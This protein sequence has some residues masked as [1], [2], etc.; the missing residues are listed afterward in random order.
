MATACV[1]NGVSYSVPATSEENW[2]GSTKV[3]GLLIAL[4]T[5]GFQKTGGNFTLSADVDFGGSAGL[6]AAYCKSRS[7]S[8]ASAGIVRLGNA[9]VISWRNAAD[10]A[11]L[12]LTVSA[13]NKLTFAGN[14]IAG[15]AVLTASR[16]VV[17]DASG[18]LASSTVTSAAVEAYSL[19]IAALAASKVVVTD[20]SG[21]TTSVVT[22]TELA[23]LSGKTVIGDDRGERNYIH[24]GA[25]DFWQ[26]NVTQ[27]VGT[28]DT[29][30]GCDRYIGRRGGGGWT[31]TRD[32]DV[33]TQSQSGFQSKYSLKAACTSTH[34]GIS[35][36]Y[37][38]LKQILTGGDYMALKGKS[39]T[40]Q[41]WVKATK[42]GTYCV[43]FWNH[44]S[45]SSYTAEYTVSS[46]LT[47]E[48]KSV[49]LT[50]APNTEVLT[51]NASA[52]QVGFSL[53]CGSDKQGTAGSWQASTFTGTSNQVNAGD[54]TS[55]VFYL[56]QVDFVASSTAPGRFW[57]SGGDMV[58]EQRL[59]EAFYEKSYDL[60]VL[61]GATTEVGAQQALTLTTTSTK[62]NIQFRVRKAGYGT[63]TGTVTIYSTTGTAARFRD[64]TAAGDL[65]VTE[66]SIGPCGGSHT[67]ATATTVGNTV[68]FH[69][70]ADYRL[71]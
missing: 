13:A 48:K 67:S 68:L 2:G 70:V 50:V 54:N 58:G 35:T 7:A 39:C 41:F 30:L 33:P 34:A 60:D 18:L 57:R 45:G 69:Y 23:L 51:Q 27:V 56:S 53:V 11:N 12:D 62:S 59:V 22:P 28:T 1:W 55:N 5:H 20:G 52:F 64:K 40:L 63:N 24:N 17:T 25:F 4:V 21:L 46:T 65:T 38:Y 47:W 32:T 9:E 36:D 14:V 43:F 26:L 44:N 42:T 3:D 61:P 8:P 29:H 6:K 37:F 16:M 71:S 19:K 10:G 66:V 49:T 15:G 31:V